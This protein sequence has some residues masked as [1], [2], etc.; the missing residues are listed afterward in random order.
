MATG[1]PAS[2]ASPE[3]TASAGRGSSLPGRLSVQA[4]YATNQARTADT[5]QILPAKAST[6]AINA[7]SRNTGR[8]SR[9]T[10]VTRLNSEAAGNNASAATASSGAIPLTVK[11]ARQPRA[12]ST[13]PV[14]KNE[15]ALP[16]A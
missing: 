1:N 15:P 5:S 10:A 14:R 11:L 12:A 7:R 3:I 9:A 13:A 4:R 16:R 8:K 2:E 6:Y